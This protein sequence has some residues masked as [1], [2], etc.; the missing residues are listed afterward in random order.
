MSFTPVLEFEWRGGG[1]PDEQVVTRVEIDSDGR[2][3]VTRTTTKTSDG[4]QRR[5]QHDSI[6][7]V[8]GDPAKSLLPAL[9]FRLPASLD[10]GW[11]LPPADSIQG[12][13]LHSAAG[14]TAAAAWGALCT[15][16]VARAEWRYA[17]F[18]T[19]ALL[20]ARYPASFG[21]VTGLRVLL[22]SY[23]G[24]AAVAGTLMSGGIALVGIPATLIATLPALAIGGVLFPLVHSRIALRVVK[25]VVF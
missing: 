16:P 19:R 7:G 9:P 14:T 23:V 22:L 21:F 2:R 20:L 8:D 12:R 18:G 11:T 1:R 10:R 3:R 4:S 6:A 17:M 13:L 24:G 15:W 25:E 5:V